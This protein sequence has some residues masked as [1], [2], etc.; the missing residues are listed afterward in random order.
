MEDITQPKT[1]REWLMKV[2]GQIGTLSDNFNT[3]AKKLVE[4]EEKK[5]AEHDERITV[6]ENIWQQARGGW[7]LAVALWLL[8]SVV[9]GWFIAW[10][11][12]KI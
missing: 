10:L 5:I 7:K 6:L 1:D 8:L 4:I 2:S 3:L 11:L 12:K 9:F